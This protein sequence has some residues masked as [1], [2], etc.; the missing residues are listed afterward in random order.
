MATPAAQRGRVPRRT[1]SEVR[2]LTLA[3]A[4]ELFSTRGY[5]G[6]STRR[7]AARA[8]VAEA[9]L[10]R[11]FGNKAQLFRA[12]VVDPLVATLRDY[13]DQR[14][15]DPHEP[16]QPVRSFIETFYGALSD[17]RGFA[18]ALT[19]VSNYFDDVVENAGVALAEVLRAI[20]QVVVLEA[21]RFGYRGLNQPVTARVSMGSVLATVVF[22][23]WIFGGQA[24][25][26]PDERIIGELE[27]LMIYGVRG[28]ATGL[29]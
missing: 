20:E 26:L 13:A 24:E 17:R 14:L 10:F 8:G 4:G 15:A 6:A 21:E 29:G 7:I 25:V 9:L 3:S 16:R 19:A 28:R 1:H 27:Q 18:M 5:I 11:H 12:A 22:R 2:E 23:S